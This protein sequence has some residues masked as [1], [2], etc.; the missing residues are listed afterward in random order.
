ME[1]IE[2]ID[3]LL[4]D[5]KEMERLLMS[6]RN[7]EVY[8]VVFF[9][10]IFDLTHH[11]MKNV[12]LLEGEQIEALHKQM[13]EYQRVIALSQEQ[14][15]TPEPEIRQVQPPEQLKIQSPV[16]SKSATE[17]GSLS[18]QTVSLNDV[19]GKKNLSDFRKAL[20]LNDRFYF[21]KE[22]FAGDEA[23]MNK[24]LTDLNDIHSYEE[25][26]GYLNEKFNWDAENTTVTEFIK[27]I[28]K[29][30]R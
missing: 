18:G 30:F 25:S 11:L 16:Q 28:E 15:E 29:R 9:S 1:N 23:K 5:I 13:E 6:V 4:S 24:V 8:P 7:E 2:R 21:R 3:S 27:L 14:Q 10:K 12:H 20:S 19:L 17:E 26:I 22:L